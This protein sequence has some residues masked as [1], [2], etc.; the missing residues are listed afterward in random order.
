MSAADALA[1]V[2]FLRRTPTLWGGP[3][4]YKEWLHFAVRCGDLDLLLNY[5]LVDD[6]RPE[7]TPGAERA[8][9]IAIARVDGR[10]TGGL[11]EEAPEAVRALGGQLAMTLGPNRVWLEGGQ[12]HLRA[13]VRDAD[14]SA[15]LR[16]RPV[17]TPLA[18]VNGRFPDGTVCNWSTCPRLVVDGVVRVGSVERTLCNAVGYHDHNWGDFRWGGDFAWEWAYAHSDDPDDPWTVVYARLLD[19]ARHRALV[20]GLWIW[21]DGQPVRGYRGLDLEVVSSGHLG[22][23]HI[24]RFPAIT[25]L[26]RTGRLSDVPTTL[27]VRATG[28]G[29]TLRVVFASEDVSQVVIPSDDDPMGLT[30]INEVCGTATITGRCVGRTIDFEAHA[31]AEFVRG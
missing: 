6:V 5:S 25:G 19:R 8:R 28:F 24:P 9:T 26:L 17:T 1:R 4:G 27:E 2:G 3:P 29:D 20:Q 14:L 16:M 10:W 22:A 30:V 23:R 21:R 31:M 18:M 11:D 13:H 12:L 7:A 15:A